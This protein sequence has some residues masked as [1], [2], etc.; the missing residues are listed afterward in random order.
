[1]RV[2]SNDSF[3]PRAG[4]SLRSR[5]LAFFR[6]RAQGDGC[7]TY[8]YH[9]GAPAFSASVSMS[10]ACT[11]DSVEKC[12]ARKYLTVSPIMPASFSLVPAS[13]RVHHIYDVQTSAFFA[14]ASVSAPRHAGNV[15]ISLLAPRTSS[16]RIHVYNGVNCAEFQPL[17]CV[18]WRRGNREVRVGMHVSLVTLRSA[19]AAQWRCIPPAPAGCIRRW[20][21]AVLP[22][23]ER[24]RGKRN[25]WATMIKG[26]GRESNESI[27]IKITRAR[28]ILR[29][30]VRS[31]CAAPE[32]LCTA[33][34]P[35]GTRNTW[36]A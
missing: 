36:H 26:K 28:G 23:H 15:N 6:S 11:R 27:V 7:C 30:F 20:M 9:D 16:P 12:I 19:R 18:G 14:D 35:S 1:M 32:W 33:I 10:A 34:V 25:G 31:L 3:S 22:P 17:K 5:L 29:R 24:E 2:A 13:Y 21:P 8:V 4:N